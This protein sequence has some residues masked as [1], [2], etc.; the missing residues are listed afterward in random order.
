MHAKPE[1][2]AE[3]GDEKVPGL[4]TAV[5]K[6]LPNGKVL[7]GIIALAGFIGSFPA[8]ICIN[9]VAAFRKIESM[10]TTSQARMHAGQTLD[11]PH[12]EWVFV[13]SQ[14]I[15]PA[16]CAGFGVHA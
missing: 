11:R 1:A 13:S 2:E 12:E 14:A 8:A 5:G 7:V 15:A 6:R 16:R 9:H 3:V 10:S 4:T